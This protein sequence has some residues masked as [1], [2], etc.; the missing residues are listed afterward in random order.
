MIAIDIRTIFIS[1]ILSSLLCV[2]VMASLWHQNRKRSPEITLWLADYVLQFS[3]ILL[4]TLRG[5]IPD[6][7]SIVLAN[8]FIVGGTVLLYQG[9]ERYVGKVTRQ[10]HNYLMLVVFIFLHAYFTFGYPSLTLRNINYSV[11]F[12]FICAQCSWLML[13]RVDEPLREATMATG[14]V[15]A[16]FCI[17]SIIQIITN[18]TMKQTG[19]IF[20]SGV[21]AALIIIA[22][23]VLLIAL[24]FVLFLL[25]GRRLAMALEQELTDR[26]Q[27][28]K[29]L[30]ASEER[31]RLLLDSTA[32][33][34]Y[35]IDLQ[36]NCTFANPS[37]LKMLGYTDIQQLLGKN[38]H[39]LIHHSYPGGTPMAVEDCRIYRA[40]RKGRGEHVED[41]VLWKADGTSFPAEYWSYPQISHGE[42]AGAVVTF[43]DITERKRTEAEI[44]R[45]E[46]SLREAQSIARLGNWELDL[47]TKILY[48][49]K[50]IY[51]IFEINPREFGA[52]YEAFLEAIHP[53]DRA[54]VN[55]AYT[56]SLEKRTPYEISHRLLMKDGRI[57]WVNEICRT[58]YDRQGNP[59]KSMGI[60][61]D[62][63]QRKQSEEALAEER[64]RLSYIL[65]GTNVGTW[66]W[67]IETGETIF[68]ERWA[69]IIGYT[70][71]EL[72][73]VSIDTWLKYAHP[74]DLKKSG[75]LLDKHFRKELAY[76]E[77]E[78]RMLHKNG[79]W[80]WVLDRGKV[81]KWT[82]DGKPLLMSGTHQDI[83]QRKLSEE[84]I[85]HMAT[86]DMLTDL[87]GLRLAKDRMT[88]AIGMARRQIN[89]MAV[90]FLDLDGFKLV[91]DTLGHD[92]GDSVLRQVAQQL[93]LCVRETD[94]VS[95]VGGDEFLIIATNLR[96]VDNAGEIAGK[97]ISLLS[98]PFSVKDKQVTIGASIGIALYPDNG[99]DVEMLIKQ[100]DE[101]MYRIKYGG[102][103][104][105]GFADTNK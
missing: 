16:A 56:E 101:A 93:L 48:W 40:F 61:Q 49:S 68:N 25:V 66:E 87:P 55:Q 44:R 58:E 64:Q 36:G 47:R 35:G 83:N 67:N 76:Y 24:T 28:E 27:T 10:W 71:A 11:A 80:V 73:P 8:T 42:I 12:L 82:A 60:V 6:F 30:L 5:I 62:I 100:A 33:A 22:Y 57:K 51:E 1:Y 84:K 41:E 63:S 15:F 78:A 39:W 52:S 17:F 18:I 92:A 32:E 19:D 46:E 98:R 21:F 45:H 85:Q 72:A 14:F 94:T 97:I 3:A 89:L 4:I 99:T 70:I 53:D 9:L 7:F 75:E 74:D 13:R 90:M 65:E 29:T 59:V 95:R 69:E 102:K 38:M 50:G 104:G 103:N 79:S 26:R 34:I 91:N 43:I 88:M 105:F 77:H 2:F 86:H 23:Q 20:M 81:V 31:V 96:S 54:S 37:C